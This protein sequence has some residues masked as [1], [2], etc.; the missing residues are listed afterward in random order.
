M[1]QCKSCGNTTFKQ[2]NDGVRVCV[3]CGAILLERCNPR[4]QTI[5]TL[6]LMADDLEKG[7]D[8]FNFLVGYDFTNLPY[9][10]EVGK[11]IRAVTI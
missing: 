4:E 3:K 8:G 6:R 7:C 5:K 2:D 9:D 1:S 11:A 10:V